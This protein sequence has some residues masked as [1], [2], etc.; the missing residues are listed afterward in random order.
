[1]RTQSIIVFAFGLI[2]LTLGNGCTVALWKNDIVDSW[3][4]PAT[5]SHVRLF[6]SKPPEKILVVYDEYCGRNET[7]ARGPIG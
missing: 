5:E 2:L 7:C 1:M 4:E 3:N 6:Q